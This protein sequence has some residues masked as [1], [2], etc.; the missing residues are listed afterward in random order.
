MT[1]GEIPIVNGMM[2][3]MNKSLKQL[4]LEIKDPRYGPIENDKGTILF[5][6]RN[7]TYKAPE[8]TEVAFGIVPELDRRIALKSL[9]D[10]TAKTV[11]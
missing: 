11:L 5:E 7:R 8:P 2:K 10:K 6:F 1:A 4:R 3:T 9:L